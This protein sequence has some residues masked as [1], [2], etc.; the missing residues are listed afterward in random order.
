MGLNINPRPMK[1][2]Y[3]NDN[4]QPTGE[5]EVHTTEC[6]VF[7]QI[8]SKTRLGYYNTCHEAVT[9]ARAIYGNVDGC[10]LCVPNCHTR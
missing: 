6:P 1:E 2:Y 10:K 9:A 8:A 7:A 4:P 5:H 3:V